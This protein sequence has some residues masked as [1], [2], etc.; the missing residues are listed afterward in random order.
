MPSSTHD[1]TLPATHCH[2]WPILS[3]LTPLP[4]SPPCLCI[5]GAICLLSLDS[6]LTHTKLSPH[7][8]PCFQRFA[9]YLCSRV[10]YQTSPKHATY[11]PISLREGNPAYNPS[12]S[13]LISP[14]P[15]CHLARPKLNLCDSSV[16]FNAHFLFASFALFWPCIIRSQTSH[17]VFSPTFRCHSCALSH[18]SLRSFYVRSGFLCTLRDLATRPTLEARR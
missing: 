2:H 11:N 4:D 3:A 8:M 13:A 18:A 14:L 7:I 16:F 5:L 1:V 9:I 6:S 17:H 12:H 15:Q 10:P